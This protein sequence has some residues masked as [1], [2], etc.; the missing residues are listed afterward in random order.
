MWSLSGAQ[1]LP[2]PLRHPSV[3][4]PAPW[5]PIALGPVFQIPLDLHR[6]FLSSKPTCGLLLGSC[7]NPT[8][9]YHFLSSH[10][11]DRKAGSCFVAGICSSIPEAATQEMRSS[12]SEG[13]QSYPL[14][15]HMVH[16]K[17]QLGRPHG[18]PRIAAAIFQ[19]GRN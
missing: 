14:L 17:K 3:L 7:C 10:F 9:S 1:G 16:P 11:W 18:D 12:I 6:F 15:G 4:L 5:I 13:K 19:V 2:D 8:S